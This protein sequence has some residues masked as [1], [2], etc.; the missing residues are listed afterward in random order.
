MRLVVLARY[1]SGTRLHV[2]DPQGPTAVGELTLRAP[3]RLVAA[4]GDHVWLQGGAGATLV[5]VASREL[6]LSPL[7]LRAPVSAVGAHTPGRFVVSTGG[8]I[9]SMWLQPLPNDPS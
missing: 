2:I 1:A 5:D 6:V 8:M 4:S 7:A 9:E 3:M